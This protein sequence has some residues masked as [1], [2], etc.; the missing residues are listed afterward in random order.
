MSLSK[1]KENTDREREREYNQQS[2][3]V[4]H[5]IILFSNCFDC[6]HLRIQLR[7]KQWAQLGR[8]PN[9]LCEAKGLS[10]T[11]SIQIP[12]TLSLERAT[13]NEC[14]ISASISLVHSWKRDSDD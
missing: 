14:S 8:I 7:Q 2:R 12:H 5:R 13:A 10:I 3:A 11:V 6:R 1:V 9:L 4:P